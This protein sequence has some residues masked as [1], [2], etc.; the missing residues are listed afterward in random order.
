ME[1]DKDDP[2]QVLIQ[3]L[4]S[5]RTSEQVYE[6]ASDAVVNEDGSV[7]F[8]FFDIAM[9]L[10]QAFYEVS[11]FPE[12]DVDRLVDKKKENIQ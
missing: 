5:S 9:A 10:L 6:K 2:R 4:I 8:Y 7:N 3:I 12:E 1:I 11:K